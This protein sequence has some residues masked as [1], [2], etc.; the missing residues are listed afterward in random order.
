[1]CSPSSRLL[2]RTSIDEL[3][4]LVHVLLGDMS[5]IGPRPLPLLDHA[6]FLGFDT[7]ERVHGPRL[8]FLRRGKFE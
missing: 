5:L 8:T 7:Y 3:P 4:Q 2:R 6:G 1:M